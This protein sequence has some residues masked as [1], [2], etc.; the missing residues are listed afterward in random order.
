MVTRPANSARAGG[1]SVP[2]TEPAGR[3]ELGEPD[4]LVV[5]RAAANATAAATTNPRRHARRRFRPCRWAPTKPSSTSAVRLP[6]KCRRSARLVA[7]TMVKLWLRRVSDHRQGRLAGL[8]DG[9]EA[10]RLVEATRRIGVIDA[11]T[12]RRIPLN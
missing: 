6:G 5:P 1:T 7:F 9:L 11:E 10:N 2:G 8:A 3:S 12:Q 4:W